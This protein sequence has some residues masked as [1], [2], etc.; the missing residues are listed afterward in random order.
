MVLSISTLEFYIEHLICLRQL[1]AYGPTRLRLK[2]ISIYNCIDDNSSTGPA[3]S[4]YTW[5]AL[6]MRKRPQSFW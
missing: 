5:E 3:D 1:H 2:N 6:F 4:E